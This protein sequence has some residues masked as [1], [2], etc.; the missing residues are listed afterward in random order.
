MEHSVLD[1]LR[2]DIIFLF[3]VETG[4]VDFAERDVLVESDWLIESSLLISSLFVLMKCD[5]P[6]RDVDGDTGLVSTV[7]ELE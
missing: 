6:G 2:F 7:V 1:R 4:L 5:G 3:G